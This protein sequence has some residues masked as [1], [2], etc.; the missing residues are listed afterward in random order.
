MDVQM[1]WKW[2]INIFLLTIKNNNL[3]VRNYNSMVYTPY[4]EN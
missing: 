4:A 1:W 2:S 3:P